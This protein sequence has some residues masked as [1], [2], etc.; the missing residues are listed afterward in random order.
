[1]SRTWKLTLQAE[2]ALE[3]ILVYSAREGRFDVAETIA[4]LIDPILERID[5]L[6]DDGTWGAKSCDRILGE[7]RSAGGL[8]YVVMD[9]S[10]YLIIFDEFED[11][12]EVIDIVN[13]GRDLPA[14]LNERRY[15]FDRTLPTKQVSQ[16][17]KRLSRGRHAKPDDH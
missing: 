2:A 15:A 10:G 14:Y 7:G 9:K 13:G 17:K 16:S 4:Y 8:K 3:D 12:I 6:A 1:M 11:R 5:A